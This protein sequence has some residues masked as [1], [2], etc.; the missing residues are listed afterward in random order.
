MFFIIPVKPLNE[1]K[2]RLAPVLTPEQRVQLSGNLLRRTLRLAGQFGEVVVISRDKRVRRLA[3]EA[4]AWA[5]VEAEAELNAAIRQAAG[6]IG[7]RGGQ[8]IFVLPADLP[9][10][11]P[12]DLI[13]MIESG[14]EAPAVV[15]APCRRQRGTNA[16]LL[17][18]PQLIPFAFGPD[19][20]EEHRQAAQALGLE[21]II[22]RSPT[23]AFD[24]DT[25][26]D[27]AELNLKQEVERSSCFS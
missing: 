21:P 14:R 3:K 7:G 15:L 6:W 25:P 8:A 1:S 23:V 10:L 13:E 27:W 2:S 18:P 12:A 24:L 9:L 4:G 20:F 26:E 17:R 16:L 19:S 11:A 22:Y 5:L